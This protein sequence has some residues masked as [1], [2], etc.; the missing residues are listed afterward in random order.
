MLWLYLNT[1]R[2]SPLFSNSTVKTLQATIISH[3][4][5]FSSHLTGLFV[6]VLAFLQSIYKSA[7]NNSIK[8]VS[9][10]YF[11]SQHSLVFPSHSVACKTLHD[12]PT[13]T[14][15]MQFPNF[16]PNQSYL[17]SFSH[18]D[19]LLIFKQRKHNSVS[20]IFQIL[21]LCLECYSFTYLHV[22]CPCC[23]KFFG[24]MPFSQ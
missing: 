11:S 9:D 13:V 22:L 4:D 20:G 17:L 3:L 7:G 24:Q 15:L 18:T 8:Y 23:L 14:P 12:L 6:S 10:L 1:S 16:P 2:N 21:Y 5:Y 19:H